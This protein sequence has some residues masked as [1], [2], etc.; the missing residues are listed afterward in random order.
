MYTD[1]SIKKFSK[2]HQDDYNYF[3]YDGSIFKLCCID[4]NIFKDEDCVGKI[5]NIIESELK[6]ITT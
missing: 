6:N 2:L 4:E 3:E 5:I 1:K